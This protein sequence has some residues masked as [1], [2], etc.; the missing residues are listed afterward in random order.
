MKITVEEKIENFM[1]EHREK[2]F[3]VSSQDIR[4][5]HDNIGQLMFYQAFKNN[6]DNHD[7][8]QSI[9]D[10]ENAILEFSITKMDDVINIARLQ[11]E[12]AAMDMIRHMR[13]ADI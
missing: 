4:A 8:D 12:R 7:L 10:I 6:K 11:I 13:D 3:S 2:L 5:H 9:I 1:K